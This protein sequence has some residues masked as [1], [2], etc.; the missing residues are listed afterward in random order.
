MTVLSK[1]VLFCFDLLKCSPPLLNVKLQAFYY[2]YFFFLQ[3]IIPQLLYYNI[4][5]LRKAPVVISHSAESQGHDGVCKHLYWS[6]SAMGL[7]QQ[8]FNFSSE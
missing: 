7:C 4:A 6:E 2:Y 8:S 3:D 5:V 1:I